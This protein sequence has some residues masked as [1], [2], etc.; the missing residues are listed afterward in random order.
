M[1]S[2]YDDLFVDEEE[3]RK[4]VMRIA[5]PYLRFTQDGEILY[6]ED[7]EKL[8]GKQKV[9]LQIV[10]ARILH[11]QGLRDEEGIK[12]GEIAD[13]IQKS[14]SSIEGYVYGSLKG[15]V[16]SDNGKLIIPNSKLNK[17]HKE[18]NG[19]E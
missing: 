5:E 19:G 15:V 10:A 4:R 17:A 16:E 12:A 14:K 6:Q 8:T 9:L 3:A 1:S 11:A 18:V 13:N 7:Y 2:N